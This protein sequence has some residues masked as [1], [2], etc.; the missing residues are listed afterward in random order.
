MYY[1]YSIV[2]GKD[3]R[4]YVGMTSSVD[5][6]VE[7]HNSGKTKSTKY[8]RPWTLFYCES[9]ETRA[10]ARAREKR[11]KSSFGKKLLKD[12]LMDCPCSSAG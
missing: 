8:Y 11:L 6:R 4:I 3:G 10:E 5:K 1:V 9:F 7:E 2:S 12:K